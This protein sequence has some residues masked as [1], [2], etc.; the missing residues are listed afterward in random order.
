M[1]VG[2]IEG[3]WERGVK[4]K[5]CRQNDKISFNFYSILLKKLITDD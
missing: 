1:T 2:L 3:G 5:P 4:Y